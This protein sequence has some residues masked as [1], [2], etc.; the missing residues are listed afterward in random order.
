MQAIKSRSQVLMGEQGKRVELH[1]TILAEEMAA[2]HFTCDSYG[3][4]IEKA[5]GETACIRDITTSRA[6]IGELFSLLVRNG[7][8]PMQLRDV[9]EDWL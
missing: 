4:R 7:V 2:G 6:R 9:V 5:D 8:T 3:I 1:Y